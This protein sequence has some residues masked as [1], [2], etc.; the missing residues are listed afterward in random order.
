MIIDKA[1]S[2]TNELKNARLEFGKIELDLQKEFEDQERRRDDAWFDAE[3]NKQVALGERAAIEREHH[4]KWTALMEA[5]KTK[6]DEVAQKQL[7][8]IRKIAEEKAR[9]QTAEYNEFEQELQK[10]EALKEQYAIRVQA[11]AESHMSEQELLIAKHASELE[12]LRQAREAEAITEQEYRDLEYDAQWAHLQKIGELETKERERQRRER[13]REQQ[14][15]IRGVYDTMNII[16]TLMNSGSRELF[17][18]GKAAAIGKSIMDTYAAINNTMASV[19]FPYNMA[20]A[21]A[22]GIAGFANVASIQSQSYGSKS[23]GS[24]SPVMYSGGLPAVNTTQG[25]AG[26]GSMQSGAMVNINLEGGDAAVFSGKQVRSLIDQI[27]EA[28]GDG[29]R[30]R[31]A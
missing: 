20:A 31:L 22:V 12:I 6:A 29:A 5:Q 3:M 1:T 27:N 26:G 2:S 19:P 7:E 21:A 30:I 18:I 9:Y 13:E 24:G 8:N 14:A 17:E 11:I 23:G 28:V 10:T 4:D 16:S 15:K 25:G